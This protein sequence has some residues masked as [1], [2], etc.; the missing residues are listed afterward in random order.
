M[1]VNIMGQKYDVKFCGT[2]NKELVDADGVCKVYD[3][4]IFIRKLQLMGGDSAD[5]QKYR[6]DHVIRHELVHAIA[7]ESG[8][9]YGNNEA[10]VDWIAHIIPLVNG[11][12]DKIV[13]GD[14]YGR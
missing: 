6:F 12:Y 5:A 2:E 4:V 9:Q 14:K 13:E 8:V 3:K 1:Q 11:A 10:L 7:E